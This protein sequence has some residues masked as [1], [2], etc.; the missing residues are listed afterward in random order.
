MFQYLIAREP[1][2]PEPIRVRLGLHIGE[3]A[4]LGKEASGAPKLVGLAADL[5]ARIMSLAQP[6][7][8][9]MT[10][11]AFDDARQYVR[12]HPQLNG[13][14]DGE[15]PP[16]KWVAHGPYLFKGSDEP[17]DLFEVGAVGIAPLTEPPD[18]EKARR[19]VRAGEED[20]LGWRPAIG[21]PVPGRKGWI[22]DQKLGEGGF[23]EVWLGVHRRTKT[24]RVFKFCFDAERLR[25]FKRELTLFRLIRYALGERKD[26]ATIYEVQLDKPPYY[27]ESEFT[28]KGDMAAWAESQGGVDKV[29]LRLRLDL[30][31]RTAAAVAAAHS[32][33]IL[34]KDI[35]P[36][37]ILIYAG[38]DGEAKP[39]LADFGIGLVT[40]QTLLH[41]QQ[42]TV[43][44]FT[45]G[46][47]LGNE[48]SR[49]GTRLYAPPETLAGHPF[50]IQGDIYA[51]GVLLYQM[52]VGDLTRPLATGWQREVTDPL[53]LE[54]ISLCVDGDPE[55]R[56]RSAAELADRLDH[57]DDRREARAAAELEERRAA[58]RRRMIRVAA[59][60]CVVLA[61]AAGIATL[62]F[63]REKD[64]RATAVA[65]EQEATRQRDIAVEE[66]ARVEKTRDFLADMVVSLD[67]DIAAG[68]QVTVLE[69][70]DR[71]AAQVDTKLKDYPDIASDIRT[72]IGNVYLRLS[73]YE[74]ALSQH[75]AAYKERVARLGG[76]NNTEVAESLFHLGKVWWWRGYYAESKGSYNKALTLRQTL[77][78]DRH[79]AV[80]EATAELASALRGNGEYAEAEKLYNLA[81]AMRRAIVESLTSANA[82]EDQINGAKLLVAAT[83]NNLGRCYFDEGRYADA[84]R[85][86]TDALNQ[87]QAVSPDKVTF[88]VRGQRNLAMCLME[89]G[90]F[91]RADDQLRQVLSAQ[92]ERYGKNAT[93]TDTAATLYQLARLRRMTGHLAE[94]REFCAEALRIQQ[95]RFGNDNPDLIE[96]QLLM[97]QILDESGEHSTAEPMLRIV[98]DIRR[99][100]L[101]DLHWK[102]AE[103]QS[104]YGACLAAL[105]KFD[106]A[107]PHLLAGYQSMKSTR[108]DSDT[109]TNSALQRVVDFYQR[110]NKPEK[111][112]EFRGLLQ[113]AQRSV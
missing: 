73:E 108:G 57:L 8:M 77:I 37:N 36:K 23:G 53:L 28:D 88:L 100:R 106:E 11:T 110:W 27:L 109:Y 49:T 51:L 16:L 22:L 82:P 78:P 55:R 62:M 12:S 87:A 54:D 35:K 70:I 61:I 72:K 112:D 104:S 113:Q 46:D 65:A 34:H 99:K 20:L 74:K 43:A 21:L 17:L 24:A 13:H 47:L 92:H 29:P 30:V 45:E 81:L 63:F 98:Y 32:V 67:P 79:D 76:E 7:Q 33:G 105:G 10:R 26:I 75:E 103:V 69:M 85:N 59:A 90:E 14:G 58:G 66:K 2:R 48:S 6:G 19:A 83:I 25:S 50:T 3:V 42:I 68:P 94:A 93:H 64:L 60:A 39:R 101:P 41:K 84:E 111:A 31:A 95:A 40:D 80:A 52:V 71:A 107:E 89:K 44:G 18:S 102:R 56:L 97:G 9:L 38:D 1:W 4:E 86:F 91:G 5:A 96:S 15:L